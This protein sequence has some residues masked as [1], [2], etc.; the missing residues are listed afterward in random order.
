M[1]STNVKITLK[2]L[3]D[4][5]NVLETCRECSDFRRLAPDFIT[6]FNSVLF[7]LWRKQRALDLR[8]AYS[9][10][11]SAKTETERDAAR[12]DYLRL[13]REAERLY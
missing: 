3:N 8:S 7:E 6:Y 9:K 10:L 5:V 13:K 12:I 4:I 2:L 1:N 11:L